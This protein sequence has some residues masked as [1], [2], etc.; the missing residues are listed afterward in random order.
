MGGGFRGAGGGGGG[1]SGGGDG[2]GGGGGS[3]GGARWVVSVSVCVSLRTIAARRRSHDLA[4]LCHCASRCHAY[5]Q[6]TLSVTATQHCPPN[7]RR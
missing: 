1:G 7:D 2:G 3:G 6:P 4:T 5:L